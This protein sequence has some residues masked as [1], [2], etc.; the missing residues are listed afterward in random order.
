MN[1]PFENGQDAEHVMKAYS[2]LKPGGKMVAITSAGPF[3]REDS[4]SKNFRDWLKSVGGEFEDMAE[5]SFMG[6]DSFRQTGVRTKMV[7][8]QKNQ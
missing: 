8:I 7:T 1:P 2:M 5:G 3:F 6:K 4:K